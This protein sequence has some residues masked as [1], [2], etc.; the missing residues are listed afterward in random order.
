MEGIGK[1]EDFNY[2]LRKV[3]FTE[4][5]YFLFNIFFLFYKGKVIDVVL[6]TKGKV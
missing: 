6:S 2:L 5:A 1:V 4:V 3:F